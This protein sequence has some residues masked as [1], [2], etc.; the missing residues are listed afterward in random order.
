MTARVLLVT[1]SRALDKSPEA[2]QAGAI[3]N[4]I[5]T[6]FAPTVIVAGDASGPDEWAID[7]AVARRIDTRIYAL[8]GNVRRAD[9]TV[10]RQ[11]A[12]MLDGDRDAR[13]W[14]LNRNAVMVR[15]AARIDGA[16][17]LVL[18][19][20][21]GWSATKGTAHTVGRAERHGLA[22]TRVTFTRERSRG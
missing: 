22:V 7:L 11:W 8:D 18:A 4:V 21:A 16:A 17:V 13:T 19:L 2:A 12:A 5:A 1:G 3:L 6:A 15:D 10:L 9:G 14:P 20:E